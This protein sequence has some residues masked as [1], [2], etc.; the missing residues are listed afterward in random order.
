MTMKPLD[1]LLKDQVAYY[2]A[3]AAEYDE[4]VERTGRYDHGPELNRRWHDD[5]AEV[6]RALD[7]F[8]PTGRVLE[9]AAGTGQWTRR[10]LRHADQVTVLDASPEMLAIN[11]AKVGDPKVRHVLADVFPWQPDALYDV[12]LFGFWLSHVPPERF[13]TF[14][15]LVAACLTPEGRVFFVDSLYDERSTALDH[16]LEG[17]DKTTARRRLNDGREFEIVK[18]F[19]APDGQTARLAELGWDVMVKRTATYFLYGHG[20]RQREAQT[21]G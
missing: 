14:W 13:G 12:V 18:V 1:N 10:L 5:L 4:W 7:E 3:R 16:R 8:A 11:R 9:I 2:R 21:D 17:P 15:Q 6:G 19:Y 20:E